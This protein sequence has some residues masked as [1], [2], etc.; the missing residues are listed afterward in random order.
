MRSWVPGRGVLTGAALLAMLA[1]TTHVAARTPVKHHPRHHKDASVTPRPILRLQLP[2]D[3]YSSALGPPR[4]D[5]PA[6]PGWLVSDRP[7]ALADYDLPGGANGAVGL[8]PASANPFLAPV[9]PGPVN[10]LNRGEPDVTIGASVSR[11]F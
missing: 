4:G 9:S 5:Y 1:G 8:H 2:A 10:G 6:R 3:D 7:P 11:P